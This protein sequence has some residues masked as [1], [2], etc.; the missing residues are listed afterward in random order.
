MWLVNV[1]FRKMTA[2]IATLFVSSVR[3]KIG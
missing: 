3:V 2:N 1:F